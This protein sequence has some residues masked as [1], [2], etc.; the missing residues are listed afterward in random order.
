MSYGVIPRGLYGQPQMGQPIGSFPQMG[1]IP[2]GLRGYPQMGFSFAT[3]AVTK[4]VLPAK[5]ATWMD[6]NKFLSWTLI[7]SVVVLGAYATIPA[8]KRSLKPYL[9]FLPF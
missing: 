1:V 8:V 9:S 4:A 5:V 3:N 7:G 2:R 6:A